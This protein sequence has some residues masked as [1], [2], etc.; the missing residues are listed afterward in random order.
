MKKLLVGLVVAFLLIAGIAEGGTRWYV[1]QQLKADSGEGASVS[2]GAYP[3]VATLVTGNVKHVDMDLPSTLKIDYPDG[4][5]SAPQVTGSPAST[6]KIRNLSLKDRNNP[7]AGSMLLD[8]RLTDEFMLAQVQSAIAEQAA[9]NTNNGYAGALIQ[10]LVRVTGITS[11]P[12]D[13]TVSVEFTDGA[14]TLTLRP[15][16]AD[17]QLQFQAERAALFGVELPKEMSEAITNSLRE[18]ASK[19]AGGLNVESVSVEDKAVA[20]R[21]TGTNVNFSEISDNSQQK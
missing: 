16:A 1:S 6:V 14:A 19:M 18:S 17:G 9:D 8:T 12:N 3:V 5:N 15:S 20:L 11:H 13:G 10:S 2:F 7:V 21:L 4:T